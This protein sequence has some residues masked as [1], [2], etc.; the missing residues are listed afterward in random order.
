MGKWNS[1]SISTFLFRMTLKNGFELRISFL[2]FGPLW[3]TEAS[4]VL[5]SFFIF[6]SLWKNGFEFRFSFSHYFEKRIWISFL[7]FALLWKTDLNFVF[8]FCMACYWKIDLNFVCHFSMTWKTDYCTGP[9]I[10][11][12]RTSP[13]GWPG[14]SLFMQVKASEFF[15]PRGRSEWWTPPAPNDT[16][17]P[18][19]TPFFNIE[20]DDKWYDD[21]REKTRSYR[22]TSIPSMEKELWRIFEDVTTWSHKMRDNKK[23]TN[24]VLQSSGVFVEWL[25]HYKV[26]FLSSFPGYNK[27]LHHKL[28]HNWAT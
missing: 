17:Y 3:K 18:H 22:N 4:F 21:S 16:S 15:S 10:W 27:L 11:S 5:I 14:H 9:V 28:L 23:Y 26:S 2:V 7:V 12:P 1:S 25:N 24:E 13:Q 20:M 6:A 8:R 19:G